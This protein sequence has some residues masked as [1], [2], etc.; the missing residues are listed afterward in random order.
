MDPLQ[1][2]APFCQDE[3]PLAPLLNSTAG[4]SIMFVGLNMQPASFARRTPQTLNGRTRNMICISVL[5]SQCNTEF[6]R[7][8]SWRPSFVKDSVFLKP[9]IPNRAQT[10]RKRVNAMEI[11]RERCPLLLKRV[12]GSRV[13]VLASLRKDRIG[14]LIQDRAASL[15]LSS[16]PERGS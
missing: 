3:P 4:P 7:H 5:E 12:P 2:C 11:L 1:V 15:I 13:G 6:K 8:G 9:I 16:M 10:K 14:Q